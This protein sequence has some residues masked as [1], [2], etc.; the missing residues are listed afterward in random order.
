[1]LGSSAGSNENRYLALDGLRGIAAISVM[2]HHL[3]S[4]R[5]PTIFDNATVAVDLFFILSGFVITHSYG[6]RL[7]SNMS[8]FEYVCRRF[9]R[10]YP[11][12]ILGILLGGFALYLLLRAGLTDYSK[13]DIVASMIYNA[14]FLPYLANKGIQSLGGHSA[15][16]GE[17]FPTDPPAWSLFFELVASFT[18]VVL[19]KMEGKILKRIIVVSYSIFMFGV[20]LLAYVEHHRDLD[21]GQGWGTSNFLLGFPRVLFGFTF[22]VF[23]YR[24]ANDGSWIRARNLCRRYIKSPWLLY[25]TLGGILALPTTLGGLYPTLLLAIVA[26]SLVFIGASIDCNNTFDVT[27]SKFFGWISYPIYCLHFPIGRAVFVLAAAAYFSPA[28]AASISVV[29]TAAAAAV[30]TKFYDEPMRA[31]LSRKLLARSKSN[32]KPSPTLAREAVELSLNRSNV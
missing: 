2:L 4:Y 6:A 5:S 22:G 18:F 17:V 24:F 30:F 9:I 28:K 29:V 20:L 10:L 19:L 25:L 12:F 1:M 7:Q 11:M 13:R 21:L 16:F 14:F 27:I 32:G 31:Y 23:L 3:I 8:L 26:P 15:V